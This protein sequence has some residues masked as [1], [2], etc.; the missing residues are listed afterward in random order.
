MDSGC[1]RP[2]PFGLTLSNEEFQADIRTE[3]DSFQAGL[4]VVLDPWNAAARDDKQRDYVETFDKLR[5]M[6]PTGKSRPVL[7]VIAHT[8]K[9]HPKEMRTGGLI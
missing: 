2:P 1:Q 6:L 3:L 4:C 8:R 5:T 9:P 7:A